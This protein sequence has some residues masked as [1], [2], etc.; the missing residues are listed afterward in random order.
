[1]DPIVGTVIKAG[2]LGGSSM[3]SSLGNYFA[4][5]ETNKANAKMN[6][7]NLDFQREQFNYQK[8]LNNNQFQI[9]SADAQKS[10]INPLAMT[11]GSLNGG[12]YSNASH[13]METPQLGDLSNVVSRFLE[14]QTQKEISDKANE[15][16]ASIA[17]ANNKNSKDIAILKVLSDEKIAD[18]LNKAQL[19]RLVRSLS[20]Q[21]KIA[22]WTVSEQKRHNTATES[23]QGKLVDSQVVLNNSQASYNDK[24]IALEAVNSQLDNYIKE[25]KNERDK[26]ELENSRKQLEADI[27]DKKWKHA[28]IVIDGI[29]GVLGIASNV[30]SDMLPGLLQGTSNKIGF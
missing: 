16:N 28:K 14:M 5:K 17:D 6:D 15:T 9:Q 8:Y 3:L 22:S 13:P 12:S 19:D 7:K 1:M 25:V 18:N 27:R 29:L 4:T 20:S 21:E 23:L 11:V 10:G 2:I 26:Q 24:K 30:A